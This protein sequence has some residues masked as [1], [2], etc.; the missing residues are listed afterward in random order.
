MDQSYFNTRYSLD[1]KRVRVWKAISEYLQEFIPLQGAVLEAG[2]GYCDFINHIKAARKYAVDINPAVEQYCARDVHFLHAEVTEPLALT[3][4]SIDVVMASNLLE[5]LSDQQC[6]TLIDR[7]NELLTENGV[8]ILIQPNYYYCYRQYWDDFTH[9]K[10]FSHISLSDFLR[11]RGYKI[12]RVEK[13]L[14]PFSFKSLLP[15]SYWITKLYLASFW[16]P[17]AKQMLIVAQR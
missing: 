8:L 1:P 13:K 3:P 9:V 2:A 7:F 6:S 5:H 11:S 14:L 15:K 12:L 4:H 16:R 10:A 17:L